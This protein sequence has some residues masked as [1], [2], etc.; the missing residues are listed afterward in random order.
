MPSIMFPINSLRSCIKH[1][2]ALTRRYQDSA[3]HTYN[4]SVMYLH[5]SGANSKLRHTIVSTLRSTDAHFCLPFGL[6]VVMPHTDGEG[7]R[8]VFRHVREFINSQIYIGGYCVFPRH[9]SRYHLVT[10]I[11]REV[12][13]RCKEEHKKESR[14][15]GLQGF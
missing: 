1:Q 11:L 4:F 14:L 3:Q 8:I 10:G 9:A 2:I 13:R 15:R 5:L 6:L 7:A 12:I